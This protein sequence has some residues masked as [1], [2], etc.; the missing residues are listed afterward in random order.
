[1]PTNKKEKVQVICIWARSKEAVE[2]GCF[3]VLAYNGGNGPTRV[4]EKDRLDGRLGMFRSAPRWRTPR[5]TSVT[6]LA[7]ARDV[8][9]Q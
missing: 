7:A 4:F 6:T 5:R 3:N 1:M 2:E 8:N 9:C